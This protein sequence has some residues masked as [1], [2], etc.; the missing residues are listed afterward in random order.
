MIIKRVKKTNLYD[1]FFGVGWLNHTRLSYPQ[2]KY[3]SG[4]RLPRIQVA[5]I[6][7][8]IEATLTEVKGK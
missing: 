7:H 8:A 5:K 1:C 3:V 4:N 2:M 6:F